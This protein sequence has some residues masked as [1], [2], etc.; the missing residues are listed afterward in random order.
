M[1]DDRSE[2]N[3]SCW[4]R[5]RG[6]SYDPKERPELPDRLAE[7][8]SGLTTPEEFVEEYGPLGFNKLYREESLPPV[9]FGDPPPEF[10]FATNPG[11]KKSLSLPM[12]AYLKYR[13]D[14]AYQS[15]YQSRWFQAHAR[16][17]KTALDLLAALR[18]KDEGRL[19]SLLKKFPN[20]QYAALDKLSAYGSFEWVPEYAAIDLALAAKAALAALINPN[21]EGLQRVLRGDAFGNLRYEFTFQSL[22]QVIYWHMAMRV[23]DEKAVAKFCKRCGEPF[24]HRDPRQKYCPKPLGK[25]RSVCGNRE[26]VET[27]RARWRG[28]KKRRKHGRLQKR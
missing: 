14:S 20:W 26:G 13:T 25:R 15:A 23:D 11:F 24:F 28:A 17:V 22:V 9:E 7:V 19:R 21:L 10:I 8:A 2:R 3:V 18:L 4:F 5:K 1:I 27:Y 6:V 12:P 16:T